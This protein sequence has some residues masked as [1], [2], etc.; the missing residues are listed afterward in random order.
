M[1]A[2]VRPFGLTLQ[3]DPE[4][5]LRLLSI[6]SFAAT[7]IVVYVV[8][9]RLSRDWAWSTAS[10][11]LTGASPVLLFYAFEAGVSAFATFGTVVYL[12]LLAA[13]LTHAKPRNLNIAGALLGILLGHLHLY[14]ACI[15]AGLCVGAAIRFRVARD[16]KELVT[17][18][19]FAVPGLITA[20][21]EGMI[22]R[23][24]DPLGPGFPLFV[25]RALGALVS[26]TLSVFS[27]TGFSHPPNFFRLLSIFVLGATIAVVLYT[28]KQSPYI[29][30]PIAALFALIATLVIGSTVGYMLLPRY[31]VPLFGALLL[32]FTFAFSKPARI[33]VIVLAAIELYALPGA[34]RDTFLKGNGRPIAR[35]IATTPRAGT[36]VIVQHPLRL[37]YPDPLHSFV[38]AFYLDERQPALSRLPVYE[39]PSLRDVT[40]FEGVLTYFDGGPPLRTAFAE[41]P[42]LRWDQQL[43][44][45]PWQRVWLITPVPRV[46][47]EA[48]QSN[49]F[50]AALQRTGFRLQSAH[51]VGGY[52]KSQIGLFVRALPPTAGQ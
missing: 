19:A 51:L 4:L 40:R 43:S 20:I 39:L 49:A 26:T 37:G 15:F 10:A 33:C 50:R 9:F 14:L 41:A 5:F 8:A 34:L 42:A 52:P 48:K 44:A 47:D 36:A 30:L 2:I 12:A 32:A 17:I 46:D 27:S 16:R 23:L 31:Q 6:V 1:H 24:T 25:R 22:I 21:A 18:A 45:A 29:V 7:A 38:L 35:L 13:A 3:R 11:F 28:L